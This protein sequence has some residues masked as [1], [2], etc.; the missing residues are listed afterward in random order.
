MQYHQ[1]SVS[2]VPNEFISMTTT[3]NIQSHEET[4]D[5]EMAELLTTLLFEVSL[6][7]MP[8][9]FA[10][11]CTFFPSRYSPSILLFNKTVPALSPEADV[12]SLF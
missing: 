2:L 11:H 3:T 12:I 1:G 7:V 4:V 9:T 5:T 6:L 8:K 10:Q